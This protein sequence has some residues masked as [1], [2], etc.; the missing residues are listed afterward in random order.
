MLARWRRGELE[1]HPRRTDPRRFAALILD[2]RL[3]LVMFEV[4]LDIGGIDV[5]ESLPIRF[6]LIGQR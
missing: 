1:V 2:K 5:Y 3:R 6:E 4:M